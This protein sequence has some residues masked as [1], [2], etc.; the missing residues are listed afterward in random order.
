MRRLALALLLLGLAAPACDWEHYAMMNSV[1]AK[2][3][4]SLNPV[5]RVY[6]GL[7]G[8]SHDTVTRAREQGAFPSANL[9]RF[10]PMFPA[11][12]DASWTRIL[13]T[14]RFAGLEFGHYDPV[15]DKIYNKAIGGLLVHLVPPLEE[16][17]FTLPTYAQTPA[18]Y[19]AFDYHAS[20]YLDALWS[21][22]RPFY[23]YYRGLDNLF[24][25]LE[26]R[27]Q[28]Q[29]TFSAYVLETDVVGHI[30]SQDDVV[31]ALVSLSE[32]IERFK[33]EHPERTFVFTLFGD[34]GIDGV[35]KPP[36]KRGGL[37]RPAPGRGRGHGG[38]L[39]GR[40]QGGRARGGGHPPHPRHLCGDPRPRAVDLRGGA[41]GLHLRGGG[42]GLR[43][44]RA[45]GG[46]PRGP[47]SG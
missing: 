45:A 30:R 39:R 26:G 16:L 22:D 21:Y 28:V 1:P 4:A 42:S 20:A 43:A 36:D 32:R 34:H 38:V 40:G 23:G 8:L 5:V 46:L 9:A 14:Q 17:P 6:L 31:N 18:Y 15:K 19:K 12:S 24:V 27:S 7:D 41:P 3:D 11:T 47:H 13:H 2:G 10:I 44:R 35:A 33:R 37:P 25:A 29:D